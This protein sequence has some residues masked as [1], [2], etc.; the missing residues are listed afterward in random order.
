MRVYSEVVYTNQSDLEIFL[1]SARRRC[2]SC[3]PTRPRSFWKPPVRR[4][5]ASGCAVTGSR[6]SWNLLLLPIIGVTPASQKRFR[7]FTGHAATSLQQM[8]NVVSDSEGDVF[9]TEAGGLRAHPSTSTNRPGW[10][11]KA[12]RAGGALHQNL[13]LYLQRA[14]RFSVSVGNSVR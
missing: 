6:R 4:K 9:S 8:T 3:P 1:A 13:D 14:G 7:L 11:V 12:A 10:L 2:R 5:P